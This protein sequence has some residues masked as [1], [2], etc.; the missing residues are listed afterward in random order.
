M[1]ADSSKASEYGVTD[2]C[3]NLPSS[4]AFSL[5]LPFGTWVYDTL[6]I[7]WAVEGEDIVRV[8]SIGYD[9]E[10]NRFGLR[11][12]L[13]RSFFWHCTRVWIYLRSTALY[14]RHCK[15]KQNVNQPWAPSAVGVFPLVLGRLAFGAPSSESDDCRF[16]GGGRI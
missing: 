11:S 2:K 16:A 4:V 10:I 1:R 3:L 15:I 7:N 12:E 14:V 6:G 5:P 13:L 9:N 8:R